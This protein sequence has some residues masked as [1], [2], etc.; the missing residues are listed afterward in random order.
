MI[1][2]NNFF[3]YIYDNVISLTDIPRDSGGADYD[4]YSLLLT[5]PNRTFD[6]N[7]AS[8]FIIPIPFKLLFRTKYTNDKNGYNSFITSEFDKIFA[9][10]YFNNENKHVIF[11]YD[12]EYSAWDPESY[13]IL[14]DNFLDRFKNL[15]ATRYEVFNHWKGHNA[16]NDYKDYNMSTLLCNEDG[17]IEWIDYLGRRMN[18]YWERVQKNIIIPW[19]TTRYNRP[20]LK[21][22]YEDWKNRKYLLWYHTPNREGHNGSTKIRHLPIN[23]KELFE[24]NL[25]FGIPPEEWQSGWEISKFC[26]VIRGDD[27]GSHAF[28][29]A[30]VSGSI[31]VIIS[32][33]FPITTLPFSDIINLEDFCVIFKEKDFLENPEKITPFLKTLSVDNIK[34]KL[35]NLINIQKMLLYKHPE[36][37]VPELF[38]EKCKKI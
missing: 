6:P 1:K 13:E 37:I 27:P 25:S 36:T 34:N 38:L 15:I 18:K 26:F 28:Y 33:L 14:P 35:N 22:N 20:I 4:L 2:L 17:K 11:N 7:H 10:P 29:H 32:D 16:I 23:K 5:H 31:P 12:Y 30:I 24:G 21:P 9:S 8:L 19:E 3:Y